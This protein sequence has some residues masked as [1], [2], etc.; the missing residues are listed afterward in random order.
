MITLHE[1]IYTLNPTIVTIRG[2]VAYDANEQ[3]V[4]YDMAQAETKL[5]EMQAKELKDK[6]LEE[7]RQEVAKLI[8]LGIDSAL[9]GSASG[10][11]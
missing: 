1:A 4:V 10:R 11:K 8:V 9:S 2:D 7:S 5:A 6:A 3:E